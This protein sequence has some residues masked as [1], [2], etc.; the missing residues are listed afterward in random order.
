[1]IIQSKRVYFEE[2]LQPKQISDISKA[3]KEYVINHFIN[4]Y[5]EC[6]TPN[7]CVVCNRKVKMKFLFQK[8]IEK[9]F[10]YIVTGHY[11]ERTDKSGQTVEIKASNLEEIES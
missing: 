8:M 11:A 1:M 4:E 9:G 7:P 3:F 5:R 6:R 10:D 2:K